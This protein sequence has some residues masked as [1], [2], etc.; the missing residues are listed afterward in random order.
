MKSNERTELI[1]NLNTIFMLVPDGE[2]KVKHVMSLFDKYL[3]DY[4]FKFRF[5]VSEIKTM[6]NIAQVHQH[7]V[8]E[9]IHFLINHFDFN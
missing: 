2:T 4:K 3:D 7:T 9:K 6:N 1:E 8:D 5:I